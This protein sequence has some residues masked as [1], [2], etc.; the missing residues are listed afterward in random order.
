MISKEQVKHMQIYYANK[1]RALFWY[2][3]AMESKAGDEIL[4]CLVNWQMCVDE[5]EDVWRH[6]KHRNRL[7]IA[8]IGM[9]RAV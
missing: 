7:A 4:A 6:I 5:A 8:F 9:G 3:C 2:R 1:S